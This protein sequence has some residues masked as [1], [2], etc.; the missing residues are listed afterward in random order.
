[1]RG[2]HRSSRN[3]ATAVVALA[4]FLAL[5]RGRLRTA[6]VHARRRRPPRAAAGRPSCSGPP[7][8]ATRPSTASSSARASRRPATTCATSAGSSPT[9]RATRCRCWAPSASASS[10]ATRA[11]TRP[12][13]PNLLPERHHAAVPE[14]APGQEGR[15]LRR[16]RHLRA[17]PAPQDGLPGLPPHRPDADRRRRRALTRR[18]GHSGVERAHVPIEGHEDRDALVRRRGTAGQRVEARDQARVEVRR[19]LSMPRRAKPGCCPDHMGS[20][21]KPHKSSPTSTAGPPRPQPVGHV[22][23]HAAG[24][25][26]AFDLETEAP[27]GTS[28][29]EAREA[30]AFWRERL[31]RLPWYR[32]AARA[33][34]R[35]MAARWQR[36]M[37][38]AE[39]ERW[40]LPGLT[41]PLFAVMD[42]WR[43]SRGVAARQATKRVLRTS[44]W[45]GW[46]R[47]PRPR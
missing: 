27:C 32:R 31:K 19:R 23:T 42:W 14:P 28:V 34:A 43:P 24:R 44:P 21:D 3:V 11:G 6:A 13:G 5:D 17:R 20:R 45:R 39:L 26:A 16:R 7:P 40:R 37:L 15:R 2:K 10:S 41:R 9:A 30:H 35:A 12:A 38:Q 25:P 47:W 33:E 36:R 4:A 29:A 8:A 22:R 46:S 18:R 1:M